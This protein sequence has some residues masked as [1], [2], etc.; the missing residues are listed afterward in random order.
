MCSA[1]RTQHLN[2]T[3]LLERYRHHVSCWLLQGCS[4]TWAGTRHTAATASGAAG[5]STCTLLHQSSKQGLGVAEGAEAGA[6]DGYLMQLV[7]VC[8]LRGQYKQQQGRCM[9]MSAHPR[10]LQVAATQL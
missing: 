4:T 3:P 5:S 8:L 10:S 7:P 6:K 1:V 9:C 2:H